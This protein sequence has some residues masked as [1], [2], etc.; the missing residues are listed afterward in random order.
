MILS[1]YYLVN[2]NWYPVYKLNMN[3]NTSL[4]KWHRYTMA[5]LI[6]NDFYPALALFISP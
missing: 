5:A 6:N 2:T 4:V 3:Q 1:Y